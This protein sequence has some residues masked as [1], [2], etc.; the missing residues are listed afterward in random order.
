MTDIL[1]KLEKQLLSCAEVLIIYSDENISI[2]NQYKWEEY[3][4]DWDANTWTIQ[5]G[6]TELT[7]NVCEVVNV[8]Y[9]EDG[10]TYVLEFTNGETISISIL[11]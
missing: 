7:I 9:D 2:V 5:W 3:V 6:D 10:D 4:F 8:S 11:N 1:S